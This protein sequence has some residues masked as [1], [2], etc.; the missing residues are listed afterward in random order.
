MF[1][2]YAIVAGLV[3]GFLLGGRPAGLAS[4]TVRWSAL[5]VGGMLAQVILFSAPVTERIG[6][7]GPWVYVLTTGVVLVAVFANWRIPGLAIVAL[8]AASNFVAIIANGGY[9][10]AGAG[11]MAALGRAEDTAYSNSALLAHPALEPLTD[12]FYIPRGIPFSNVF[13]VGD[14]LIGLGIAITIIIAMRRPAPDT[15]IRP[16]VASEIARPS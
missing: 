7:L 9:M 16:P 1:I 15:R 11:A 12:I 5:I 8:G 3:I 14:V 4:I 2:L 13:S 10:P 6:D